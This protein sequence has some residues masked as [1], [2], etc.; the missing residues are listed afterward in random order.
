M[1]C[2]FVLGKNKQS[3]E[4]ILHWLSAWWEQKQKD[5][6]RVESQTIARALCE[7]FCTCC[8]KRVACKPGLTGFSFPTS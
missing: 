4:D 5:I 8:Q 6:D 2:T 1:C 3:N 7:C